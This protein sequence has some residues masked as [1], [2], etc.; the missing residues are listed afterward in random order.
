LDLYSVLTFIRMRT[1]VNPLR[2]SNATQLIVSGVYR[3]SRNPM[4]LGMVLS[5]S[6]WAW[7]LGNPLALLLVWLFA[8]VLVLVQIAPEEAALRNLFG[9]SYIA[10]SKQVNRWIGRKS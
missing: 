2:P 8:R 9:T 3:V 10:Y 4:Y 6:G 5:L 1:T 7:L